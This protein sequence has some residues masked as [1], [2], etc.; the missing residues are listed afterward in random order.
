VVGITSTPVID[1]VSQTIYVEALTK[2]ATNETVNYVHRLHALDLATGAEK[3][4][5][6]VVLTAT[7][8]GVGDG[9]DGNG[10]LPF[11]AVRHLN[12]AALLLDNGVVYI[13]YASF[14]DVPP[15]HGWMFGV[16]AETLQL[17]TIFNA[18]PNGSA[19]GFWQSSCGPASDPD[20]NIFALTG[21]GT[22]DGQTNDDY[23]DCV[24][25]LVPLGTNLMLADF[26][27]PFDT[28]TLAAVDGDLGSGGH[29]LL[30][31]SAGSPEHP[32][33]MV[34]GGKTGVGYLWDRDNLGQFNP[35]DDS[36]V[37]QTFD[38]EGFSY[39]PAYF[40]GQIYLYGSPGTLGA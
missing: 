20:G 8:P 1:P 30:P 24:V 6:P 2:D 23:G 26:L 17:E 29:V 36:Q 5:G 25:K 14:D 4:G 7:V 35:V 3:P 32:H 11:T 9:N 18:S 40:N 33:L 38:V 27:T 22:F 12:R 16:N 39:T 15:Y 19:S 13:A 34:G 10:N 31:D 28:A 21:N 37:V